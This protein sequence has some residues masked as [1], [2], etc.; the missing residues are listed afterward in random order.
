VTAFFYALFLLLLGL[1]ILCTVPIYC[2]IAVF[3]RQRARRANEEAALLAAPLPGDDAL[4]E[5]LV[6]IPIFNEPHVVERAVASIADLDWPRNKLA[7]QVLDDSTDASSALAERAVEHAR[8]LGVDA[9]VLRRSER[10][11]FKAGALANGLRHSSAPFVAVF[12]ADYAPSRDWLEKAM[13]PLLRDER[14]AFVQTGLAYRNRSQNT[15]TRAQ[16]VLLDLH[17]AFE[18]PARFWAGW[19]IRFDGTCAIWRRAAIDAAGGWS[20]DTLAED[21]DISYRALAQ[22]WKAW[23]LASVRVPGELPADSGQWRIQQY[24]WTKGTTQALRKTLR[25]LSPSLTGGRRLLV[26]IAAANESL[27]PILMTATVAVGFLLLWLMGYPS[28]ILAFAVNATILAHAVARIWSIRL[29]ASV[30]GERP[31]NWWREIA[32]AGLFETWITFERIRAAASAIR[33]RRSGFV[34]T[35]KRGI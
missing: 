3:L 6:Q 7:I 11:G 28:L 10:S 35:E 1:L 32:I 27:L 8:R 19:P 31:P 2:L 15:L 33:G 26:R 5:V 20:A 9:A 34:R 21:L 25:L 29:A 18:Q 13:R 30:T 12:D 22:G 16:A 4:P 23:L 24:R 14:I 17:Y